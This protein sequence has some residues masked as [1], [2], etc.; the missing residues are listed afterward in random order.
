MPAGDRWRSVAW[1]AATIILAL[2]AVAC[3]SQ[4]PVM[5]FFFDGVPAPG[6]NRVAGPVVKSPRRD[7]YVPPP[8]P[9]KWV[10]WADMPPP[11]DWKGIYA[12][13]PRIEEGSEYIAWTK[14]L[15][16]KLITPKPGIAADAADEEPTDMDVEIATSGQPEW[17]AIFSHK[18]HTQWM[19]CDNCHATGLFEMEKGKVKMTMTGMGEGQWCGACHG[20]VAAPEL[21]G[22]AACHPAAPK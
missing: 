12:G 14:A 21:S 17:K 4:N 10:E 6:E 2:A 7:K 3:T 15:E 11:T 9:V 16:G 13:L 19:K 5:T 8:P 20:K 22:C 1:R 18:P